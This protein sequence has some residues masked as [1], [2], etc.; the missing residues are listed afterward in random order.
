MRC[1]EIS[2]PQVTRRGAMRLP[3][4]RG[5]HTQEFAAAAEQR[6][7]LHGAETGGC[8]NSPMRRKLGIGLH[9]FDNDSLTALHGS[10]ASGAKVAHLC[11]IFQK[12]FAESP[13][14]FNLQHSF[15]DVE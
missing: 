4:V 8:R 15:L 9:I 2:E 10:P 14:R 1:A 11:E 13:L 3:K 7:G 12:I 5:E 6:R